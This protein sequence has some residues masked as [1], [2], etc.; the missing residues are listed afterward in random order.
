MKKC[1]SVLFVVA[2]LF[3]A[4]RP[5]TAAEKPDIFHS[6]G[7]WQVYGDSAHYLDVGVGLFNVV[8]SHDSAG[9]GHLQLRLGPKAWFIGPTVGFLANLD[10]GYYGYGGIYGDFAWRSLILTPVLA[11]GGYEDGDGKD[12][13]G[14]FQFRL[15]L[16][17]A[18]QFDNLSRL[19]I[20]IA[21]ISN[22]NIHDYN[23]GEEEIYLNYSWP[24]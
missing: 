21:H 17:L 18:Y 23:P 3:L 12:L 5:S 11:A 2:L 22:A 10:G 6:S 4:A 1:I 24:F 15:S 14:T 13:G 8:N 16:H 7:H 20:Q 9:A 19:G